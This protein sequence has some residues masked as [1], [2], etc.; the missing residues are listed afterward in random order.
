[1]RRWISVLALAAAMAACGQPSTATSEAQAQTGGAPATS[2]EATPA[3]RSA[4]LAALS[5]SANSGGQVE[6]ECG[7]RV[8]PRFQAI[9]LGASVGRVV[10]F[11]IEGG[12]NMAS[13]YGDGPLVLL[14]RANGANWTQIYMNRGGPAIVLSTTHNG[15]NDLADGGPGFSFPVRQWNGTE[16][17]DAHRQVADSA[18][19]DARFVPN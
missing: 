18:L 1:M 11:I 2:G 10:G 16:Y 15:G 19:G 14:M 7:E 6:N 5:L 17:E 4:I 12:P 3:E 8:T 9:D 13:C